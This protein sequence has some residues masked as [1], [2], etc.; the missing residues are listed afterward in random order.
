MLREWRSLSVIAGS[1]PKDLSAFPKNGQY[2]QQRLDWLSWLYQVNRR[3]PLQ[4]LPT[5]GDYTIQH[6]FFSEPPRHMNFSASIRYTSGDYWVVMRGEGVRNETGP[7]YAQW[8]ANAFLLRERREF[9]GSDFS[10]GDAYIEEMS[11]QLA[12]TGNPETWLRAGINH[13]L[14]FVARQI[15]SLFGT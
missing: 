7:G 5:F 4:R 12:A 9:C 3:P 10:Y 8:P 13:H 11:S 2:T 1:F 15:A 14:T 6:P